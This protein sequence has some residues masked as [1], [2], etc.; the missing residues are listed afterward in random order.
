MKPLS[1]SVLLAAGAA[2]AGAAYAQEAPSAPPAYVPTTPFTA[3]SD[4]GPPHWAGDP[5]RGEP[6]QAMPRS[7]D[8][9][10]AALEAN[11]F[12][13]AEAIFNESLRYYASDPTFRFYMGVAKM[14]LGKWDEARRYLRTAARELRKLPDPKGHLGVT[15]AKLGDI[16]AANAQRARLV[17]M[18]EA[19][20]GTCE[21]SPYIASSIRMIE[22]ALAES[23]PSG[24]AA[25]G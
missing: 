20:K 11:D 19:C 13:K 24:P 2:L 8:A 9:G 4:S 5:W 22:E 3:Q 18:A 23:S 17:K 7:I 21:L 12:A 16:D 1:L 6:S 14:N 10:V 25:Q 15:Y